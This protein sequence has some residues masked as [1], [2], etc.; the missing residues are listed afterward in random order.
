[1][2]VGVGVDTVGIDRFERQLGRTPTLR[3]RLFTEAERDLPV[4]SLA[5]R[6]AAKEAIVKALGGSD[7]VGW[8]D[9]EVQGGRGSAPVFAA[10]E[11]L[12]SVF[13]QRGVD[14]A[15]LSISHDGGIATAFVVLEGEQHR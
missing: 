11:R 3:E 8:H 9:L 7:G 14:R 1:M 5:A 12:T 4:A 6:F 13:A 2:I 10:T 15:H